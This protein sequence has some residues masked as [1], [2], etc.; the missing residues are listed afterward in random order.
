[1]FRRLRDK[2]NDAVSNAASSLSSAT[3]STTD[4]T[5]D[6][7]VEELSA[8]GFRPA[9]AR[10]AL[11]EANGDWTRATEWLLQNGTPVSTMTTAVADEDDSELQHAIQ[12]SLM[13]DNNNNN[14]NNASRQ[15]RR[16]P[17]PPQQQSAASKNAG[18]AAATRTATSMSAPEVKITTKKKN[19]LT[20][21]H[22]KVQMPK[23]LSQHD[24]EDIILRCANRVAPYS[25]SVDTLLRSLKTIQSNPGNRKFH[26]VNTTTV[27]FQRSLNAPGVLDLLKAV[28]FHHHSPNNNF[29][30]NN[31]ILTLSHY[32]AAAFYLGISAL[33]QIQQT[34]P[35]YARHK[36]LRLFQKELAPALKKDNDDDEQEEASAR[37]RYLSKLP[38][39]PVTG[40]QGS[41]ITVE[42]GINISNNIANNNNNNN[43]T[44]NN[45]NNIQQ[46]M[47]ISRGFDHDDI[48]GDVINWLGGQASV[49]PSKLETGEWSLVDRNRQGSEEDY[50]YHRL[51]LSELS[52][53]TL[54]YIGCWPSGRIAIV[55]SLKDF[56]EKT[57]LRPAAQQHL[58]PVSARPFNTVSSSAAIDSSAS[59]S[60]SRGG[61]KQNN[62]NENGCDADHAIEID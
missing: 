57:R 20:T 6:R 41:Q 56:Y 19:G 48:L 32:D 16:T 2:V 61:I 14:N 51:D 13:T 22:P 29:E 46:L 11:R 12:A 38:S 7:R 39:E 37:K 3:T 54:Q 49:I 60:A 43:N 62:N 30:N 47:K 1:M 5:T 53:K 50:N 10:H 42:F 44:D 26:T 34:S 59:A 9:E 25:L 8:M 35:E 55:P 28:N 36:A 27:A 45:D 31:Q 52:S 15:R 4:T 58:L 17:P 21:T 33:E 24:Q 18:R 23:R 40:G